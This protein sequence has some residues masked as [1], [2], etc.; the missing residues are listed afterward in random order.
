MN[1][2]LWAPAILVDEYEKRLLDNAPKASFKDP[3]ACLT[4]YVEMRKAPITE[5]RLE[6]LANAFIAYSMDACQKKKAQHS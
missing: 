4:R 1:F 2:P 3:E 6:M 5:K